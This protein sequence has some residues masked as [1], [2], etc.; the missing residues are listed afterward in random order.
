MALSEFWCTTFRATRVHTYQAWLTM[1]GLIVRLHTEN[2]RHGTSQ[3][4]L[5]PC[6]HS[7]GLVVTWLVGRDV[8][9]VGR[10][11][12]FRSTHFSMREVTYVSTLPVIPG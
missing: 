9:S 11:F 10:S 5:E 3:M 2:L 6:L 12:P 8:R 4:A 7:G 1:H